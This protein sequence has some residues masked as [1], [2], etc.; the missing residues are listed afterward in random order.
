MGGPVALPHQL[1]VASS[2]AGTTGL[3]PPA[4]SSNPAVVLPA[5]QFSLALIW[6]L[7]PTVKG[8][9]TWM[10]RIPSART[11]PVTEM[12]SSPP[13][14]SMVADDVDPTLVLSLME[15]V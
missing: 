8:S 10:P 12:P 2:D 1:S 4:S 3:Y 7:G 9:S 5:M 13:K 6:R 15:L 11:F 14:R